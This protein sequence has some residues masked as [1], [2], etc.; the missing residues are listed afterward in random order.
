MAKTEKLPPNL[1]KLEFALRSI[2]YTFEAA[3]ADIVDNSI[4]AQAQEILVR[5][6]KTEGDVPDLIVADNGYGMSA[7][8]LR[9]AMRFGSDT[10][11]ETPRLGKFGLGLKL[12][13]LSQARALTVVTC[14]EGK[15]HGRSWEDD[16]I[17]QD[18]SSKIL[19][20]SECLKV[21]EMFPRWL[22]HRESWTLVWWRNLYR[23]QRRDSLEQDQ[24]I[25][26][27]V[28]L[29]KRHLAVIFHRYLQG[30]ARK[31][32]LTLDVFEP[33]TGE[34]GVPRFLEPLNPFG[35][36]DSGH[37]D[38]PQELNLIDGFTDHF[39]LTAHVWPPNSESAGYKLPGGA[40][41]RQGFYF[42]RNNRLIQAGG[43]NGFRESDPHSSLAR[44]EIDISDE[45]DVEL[46][47][48]VKKVEIQL[49]PGLEKSIRE[50]T[51][52]SGIS[53]TEYLS[54]ANKA[55][56]HKTAVRA[57]DLPLV[58]GDG[59]PARIR[60]SVKKEMVPSNK[61]K[62]REIDFKW[63][64]FED[65]SFFNIDRDEDIIHLNVEYRSAVMHGLRGSATDAPLVKSL[66]FLLLE[67]SIRKERVTKK[68]SDWLAQCN[69]ILLEC[70]KCERM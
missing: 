26:K 65:D 48:D 29:L 61:G 51:T 43:W 47:L 4:D 32:Q 62:V 67:S 25:E 27:L 13:S 31:V 35:Y 46:S 6:V 11:G 24:L 33:S 69:R 52:E 50:A 41:A 21:R 42:Y 40:N 12:A 66:L 19:S 1:A 3:V 15:I 22:H 36:E 23:V 70:L 8:S 68:E 49:P 54:I 37:P 16:S 55:Y 30:Q 17:R 18:F 28:R 14:Q 59:I 5:F 63:C 56:R 39:K 44:L 20:P 57:K 45:F 64:H 60:K 53:F 9:E 34:F 58:L 7:A 10:A 2:G 38:F